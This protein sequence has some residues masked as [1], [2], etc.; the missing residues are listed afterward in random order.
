MKTQGQICGDALYRIV[1][2]QSESIKF[3]DRKAFNGAY[4]MKVGITICI[5]EFYV[6]IIRFCI[7]DTM[8]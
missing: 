2:S 8:K 4:R 3:C 7:A 1:I 6:M 5:Y